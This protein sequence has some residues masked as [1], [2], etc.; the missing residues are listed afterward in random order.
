MTLTL[1]KPLQFFVFTL[2]I[3]ILLALIPQQADARRGNKKGGGTRTSVNRSSNKNRNV[4]VNSNKSSNTNVNINNNR[5][6]NVNVDIDVDRRGRR[7]GGVWTGVAIGVT[8]AIVIGTIVSTLPTG[9]TT[10]IQNGISYQ[11]CGTVRYQP[12]YSGN[13]VTYIVVK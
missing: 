13:N 8:S 1:N 7:R 6:R 4:N 9:C 3:F 2:S 10:I 11:Q 12:Q 5:N